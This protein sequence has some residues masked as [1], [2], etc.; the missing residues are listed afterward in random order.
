MAYPMACMDARRAAYAIKSRRIKSGKADARAL[1]E[2]PRTGW[3]SPVH[4]KPIDSHKM[5]TLP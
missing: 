2:M 5:K 1:A 4:V 3:F